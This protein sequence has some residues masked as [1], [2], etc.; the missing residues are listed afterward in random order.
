MC[1]VLP[2]RELGAEWLS[3]DI[4]VNCSLANHCKGNG[5]TLKNNL[6]LFYS[7][8]TLYAKDGVHLSRHG[9]LVIVGTLEM[10]L[11]ALQ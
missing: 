3:S 7:K 1:G 11:N 10:E 8:D 5:R 2:R 6:D 4:A 9:V